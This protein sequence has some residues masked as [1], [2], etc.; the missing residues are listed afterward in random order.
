MRERYTSKTRGTNPAVYLATFYLFTYELEFVRQLRMAIQHTPLTAQHDP[1]D[2]TLALSYFAQYDPH[3]YNAQP[4]PAWRRLE[5]EAAYHSLEVFL[6][7]H[8]YIDDVAPVQN[9]YFANL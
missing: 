6:H 4:P 7:T 5:F 3:T 9:P 8:R 2:S 1:D